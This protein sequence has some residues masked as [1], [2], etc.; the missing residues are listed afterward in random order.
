[1]SVWFLATKKASFALIHTDE[2]KNTHLCY[3]RHHCREVTLCAVHTSTHTN[4]HSHARNNPIDP[5]LITKR[6]K[7]S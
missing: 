4:T 6:E 7:S 3:R 2:H 1:M 5:D